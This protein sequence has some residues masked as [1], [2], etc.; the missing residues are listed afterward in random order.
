MLDSQDV[1][2][3]GFQGFVQN[4]IGYNAEHQ[5][6]W[7]LAEKKK[8]KRYLYKAGDIIKVNF[9]KRD[10]WFNIGDVFR[11]I[12]RHNAYPDCAYWTGCWLP[13]YYVENIKTGDKGE[14]GQGFTRRI[15]RRN[16]GENAG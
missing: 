13:L 3:Y 10:N 15:S 9:K 6:E 16:G 14:I 7:D 4:M 1:A 12:S 5:A 2:Y 11:V 8:E